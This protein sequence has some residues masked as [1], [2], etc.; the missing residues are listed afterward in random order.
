MN[1]SMAMDRIKTKIANRFLTDNGH[2]DHTS[3][4][5]MPSHIVYMYSSVISFKFKHGAQEDAL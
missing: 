5:N 2:K 4:I 3:W 1:K